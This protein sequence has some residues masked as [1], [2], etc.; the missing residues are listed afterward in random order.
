[1]SG[2][3]KV[4]TFLGGTVGFGVG[5]FF[6]EP[7]V[8]MAIGGTVGS[9]LTYLILP[10]YGMQGEEEGKNTNGS[11]VRQT[12]LHKNTITSLSSIERKIKGRNSKEQ[13]E[14]ELRN[15]AQT[16]DPTSF[17]QNPQKDRTIA[18]WEEAAQQGNFAGLYN[19][20]W[21]AQPGGEEAF[22]K[23]IMEHDKKL[24]TYIFY[25][26]QRAYILE[27]AAACVIRGALGLAMMHA[28]DQNFLD[29]KKWLQK[30]VAKNSAWGQL[31]MGAFYVFAKEE[32][33]YHKAMQWFRKAAD[34]NSAFAQV[35][36]GMLYEK[37]ELVSQDYKE[38]VKWYL[39]AIDQ[40]FG[41]GDLYNTIDPQYRMGMLYKNGQGVEKDCKKAFQCFSKV[42]SQIRGHEFSGLELTDADAPQVTSLLSQLTSLSQVDLSNNKITFQG[43]K[44]ILNVL[45]SHPNLVELVISNNLIDDEGGKELLIFFEKH[46]TLKSLNVGGN[47]INRKT[48]KS[49]KRITRLKVS[50]EKID[51][52]TFWSCGFTDTDAP[53]IAFL[54]SKAQYLNAIHLGFNEFTSKGLNIILNAFQFHLF[55]IELNLMYNKI[56]DE[57][58]KELLN[59]IQAH[60]NLKRCN[61]DGNPMSQEMQKSIEEAVKKN[62]NT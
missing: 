34:Q 50:P 19:L 26:W 46:P 28:I 31:G 40:G 2:I 14:S 17:D 11:K 43:L 62:K 4:P 3:D 13:V 54:L 27:D 39:K 21:L 57:G 51:S 24:K 60:P 42:P 30:A 33:D 36:I 32:K 49:I 16:L 25:W 1:V 44:P 41:K 55:L 38:A 37:S 20:G 9:V 52:Y 59:F 61:I 10:S 15:V 6:G 23:K 45:Q 5:L 56:D 18:L 12:T 8:G 7:T 48:N 29:A 22:F 58:G 47:A 35:L 53:E